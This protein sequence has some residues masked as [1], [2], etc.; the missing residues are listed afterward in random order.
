MAHRLTIT[1]SD[2]AYETLDELA[3]ATDKTKAEVLRDALS[4][5]KRVQETVDRRGRVL[6]E[7]DGQYRELLVR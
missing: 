6:L 2:D 3:A 4:L 7:E 5:E 1:F